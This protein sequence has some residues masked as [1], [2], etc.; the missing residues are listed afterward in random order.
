MKNNRIENLEQLQY[1]GGLHCLET[2]ELEGNTVVKEEGYRECIARTLPW[3]QEL[4]GES[5]RPSGAA[6]SAESS[7]Y[8]DQTRS[9]VEEE[10]KEELPVLNSQC[11]AEGALSL[12]ENNH[13]HGDG[14]LC[15]KPGLLPISTN[16]PT[17]SAA[18]ESEEM[19]SEILSA[20]ISL[21]VDSTARS[22]MSTGL[23]GSCSSDDDYLLDSQEQRRKKSLE[24]D[25]E[26]PPSLVTVREKCSI[27][28]PP[29]PWRNVSSR[30][31]PFLQEPVDEMLGHAS[32]ITPSSSVYMNDFVPEATAG[33]LKNT[34][35]GKIHPQQLHPMPPP[36]FPS[37]QPPQNSAM[38]LTDSLQSLPGTLP[39]RPPSREMKSK[40]ISPLE[41]SR[42]MSVYSSHIQSSQNIVDTTACDDKNMKI[43][44]LTR[45]IEFLSAQNKAL[46]KAISS[47]N[48]ALVVR[49]RGSS[50]NSSHYHNSPGDIPLS[51]NVSDRNIIS[52]TEDDPYVQL[53]NCWRREVLQLLTEKEINQVLILGS[54]KEL[55]VVV[56]LPSVEMN[57]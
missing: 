55:D 29:N 8:Q 17:D 21:A 18:A 44:S 42:Q 28:M 22:V 30:H 45:E 27:P 41:R 52:D 49:H 48:E 19:V 2:L 50:R 11:V 33:L 46:R 15:M 39:T 37:S 57:K 40:A 12:T 16:P 34:P 23:P 53:L 5:L 1:L 54:Q 14:R 56:L 20:A 3:L 47:Q 7:I 51:E 26:T 24:K 38:N 4:D 43:S 36:W 6:V 9:V 13:G 35:N 32:T 25:R 31:H 10:E